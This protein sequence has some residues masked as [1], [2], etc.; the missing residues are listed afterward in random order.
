MATDP[1]F[2]YD[3]D[4]LLPQPLVISC[5]T[6]SATGMDRKIDLLH[7]CSCLK[8]W[9]LLAFVRDAFDH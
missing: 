9:V 7:E 6:C 1:D 4:F 5:G 8:Q 2:D 3:P